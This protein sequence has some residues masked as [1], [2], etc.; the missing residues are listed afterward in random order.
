MAPKAPMISAT[1]NKPAASPTS[2]FSLIE[3][4]LVIALIAL[5][6][7][8]IVS[9]VIGLA[10]R[11]ATLPVDQTLKAAI[12]S[13]RLEAARNRQTTEL[14]FNKELGRLEVHSGSGEPIHFPLGE[15]F[16]NNG[17]GEILFE[18]IPP[19]SG[20]DRSTD[21]YD[22]GIK[23]DRVRFAPD[24][25]SQPFSVQ[26]DYGIGSPERLAFDPFSSLVIKRP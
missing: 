22:P 25:S 23:T 18:L 20:F 12:R 6:A 26:I 2:G 14:S 24:R 13:A 8:M 19:A 7:G 4:L 10:D 5:A 9:N 3:V 21:P 1:G 16:S 11:D 15:D 17:R